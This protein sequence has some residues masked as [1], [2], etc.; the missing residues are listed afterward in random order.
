[1]MKEFTSSNDVN[2]VKLCIEELGSASHLPRVVS[3]AILTANDVKDSVEKMGT[4][5]LAL[6]KEKV[7]TKEHFVAG[8]DIIM[9]NADDLSLDFPRLCEHSG[10]LLG[11]F[12]VEGVM[13]LKYLD[14]E[15][16]KPLIKWGNAAKLVCATLAGLIAAKDAS[17]MISLYKASGIDLVKFMRPRDAT[18]EGC[19]KYLES[20]AKN[21]AEDVIPLLA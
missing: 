18:K 16:I 10:T 14:T 15:I 12:A 8:F 7:L 21:I 5:L 11:R 4:I 20:G 6:L 2:E 19:T 9:E 13:E 1:M 3:G 17:T